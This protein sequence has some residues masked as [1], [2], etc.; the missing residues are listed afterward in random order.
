M[1]PQIIIIGICIL[2]IL[3]FFIAIF[4]KLVK[5]RFLV[6]EA[7]S[8]IDVQLKRRHSLIPNIVETV[9][10]YSKH[11]KELLEEIA[12]IRSNAEKAGTVG[13]RGKSENA[14]TRT[15]RNLFALQES[16]PDLKANQNFIELQKNLA[17]IEEEIALARRYYNGTV[18][19]LNTLIES[20]PSNMVAGVCGFKEE[21][22]FEIE[23]S[24]QREAPEV[25][26]S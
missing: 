12:L 3:A 7:W 8:G 18:R 9:R 22:F 1:S 26:L 19:N 4:N 24:A 13:D 11:E 23:L 15:I 14:I 6:K 10:G 21:E 17:D 2:V 5:A 25:K 16:Y 20:F